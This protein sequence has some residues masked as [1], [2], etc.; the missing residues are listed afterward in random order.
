[1]S[2]PMLSVVMP[3]YNHARY[4]P[5]AIEEILNQTRPPDEFLILDDGSTDNSVE[6]IQSY[7]ERCPRIRFLRNDQNQG[8]IDAHK[9]LFET[10]K[11]DYIYSGAVD[12][13]RYPNFFE[14]AMHMAEQHP[15]AGIV[16]GK[17]V[18]ADEHGSELG[19]VEAQRWQESLYATPETYR[20]EFLDVEEPS[21]SL[22]AATIY[23]RDALEEVGWFRPELKSW[24]DTFAARA[25]ALK[26]GACYVPEKFAAW[27]R[28]PESYSQSNRA[29]PR[30][31][32]DIIARAECLMHSA[33]FR[34]R[35]PARHVRRWK[36][37]YIWRT[38]KEYWRGDNTGEL[39]PGSSFLTRYR[40]RLPRTLS[41]LALGFYRPNLSCFA[42]E[43]KSERR[44]SAQ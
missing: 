24:S 42:G 33:E 23:R 40:Y 44:R 12:D 6:I 18:I 5:R 8:V 28:L 4:L 13:S 31:L 20:R 25:I 43:L 1:M 2:A 41:A 29:D 19:I 15:Q 30:H 14:L 22:S 35:F 7:A 3:N 17:M 36:R 27:R 32:L 37:R 16:F 38:I 26:Y 34:D 9:R 11:C 10:A 39:P 21:Q